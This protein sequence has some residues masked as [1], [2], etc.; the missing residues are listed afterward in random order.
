[1]AST[2]SPDVAL[3]RLAEDDRL[4]VV[5]FR[6]ELRELLGPR[7]RDLR[8]Y[9]SKVRG[10]DHDESDIDVLVLVDRSDG[11]TGRAISDLAYS[12][13]TWLAPNVVGF[14]AY[15]TPSSRVTGF[16]K[17]LRRESVKLL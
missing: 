6:H 5:R 3:A 11:A 8:L 4:A 7:L 2:T 10:D 15:H 1:M 12:I 13:S 9:G 16:Y 17:E 14:D